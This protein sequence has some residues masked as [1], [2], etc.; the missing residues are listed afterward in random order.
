V[1]AY[2]G[3]A[4]VF[5]LAGLV[6]RSLSRPLTSLAAAAGFGNFEDLGLGLVEQLRRALAGRRIGTVSD[7]GRHLGQTPHHRTLAD[8][9]GITTDVCR[10]RRVAR[11]R[12]DVRQPADAFEL[13]H[14]LQRLGY[15]HRVRRTVFGD[16]AYDGA[17]DLAVVL[18]IKILLRNHVTD[19]VPRAVF[20]QQSA[21][22]GL[23]GLQRV[24]RQ[25]HLRQ[26]RIGAR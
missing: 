18:T 3:F 4:L 7:A 21:K 24:G 15:R 22:H 8:D 23:F 19:P 26:L 20:E 16:L 17:Q 11:Q 9:L 6:S 2:G 14:R 5:T 10:R 25:A 12:H 13:P 1:D